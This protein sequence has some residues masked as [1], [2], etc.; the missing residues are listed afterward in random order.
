LAA[1]KKFSRARIVLMS[2]ANRCSLVRSMIGP[3]P[4]FSV[5]QTSWRLYI[6]AGIEYVDIHTVKGDPLQANL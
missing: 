2:P 6:S 1:A 4:S 5:T 3:G